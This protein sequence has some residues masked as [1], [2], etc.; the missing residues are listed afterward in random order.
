MTAKNYEGDRIRYLYLFVYYYVVS[1]LAFITRGKPGVVRKKLLIGSMLIAMSAAPSYSCSCESCYVPFDDSDA[2]EEDAGAA[3]A[4]G[5][6][7][8]DAG[9]DAGAHLDGSSGSRDKT[10]SSEEDGGVDVDDD[11][12]AEATDEMEK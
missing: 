10:D 7:R 4:G 5:E 3:G 8:N 2:S 11:A 6:Y 1:F 12:G 9:M